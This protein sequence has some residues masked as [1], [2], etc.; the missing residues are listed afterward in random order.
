MP[1]VDVVKV[2]YM[3]YVVD[4]CEIN[5]F[6]FFVVF[7]YDVRTF[8]DSVSILTFPSKNSRIAFKRYKVIITCIPIYLRV[9]R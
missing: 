8:I 6:S 5:N 9:I 7:Y 2:V 4:V 3:M 1:V